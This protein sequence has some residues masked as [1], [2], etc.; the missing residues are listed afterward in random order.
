M[1]LYQDDVVNNQ[2]SG[3]G[4]PIVADSY[5]RQYRDM[6]KQRVMLMGGAG[7]YTCKAKGV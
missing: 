4:A 1:V 3:V 7:G 5:L 6:T 2:A